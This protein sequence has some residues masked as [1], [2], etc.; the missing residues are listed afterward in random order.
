M[1]R[2]QANLAFL[3]Q[4]AEKHTKPNLNIMPGPA[5]MVAPLAPPSPDELVKL[6]T[7]LQ[8]L[9]PGWKGGAPNKPSPGPQRL[10]STSSQASLQS[11]QPPH[12]AGLH[13]NMQPPNSGGMPPNMQLPSNAMP[14][15]FQHQ[16][17]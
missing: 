6:Y 10:N 9:F 3:A 11:M 5:I 4:N 13:N 17:Q 15:N 8:S 14:N 7:R 12:S 16:Q 2:L 1:R